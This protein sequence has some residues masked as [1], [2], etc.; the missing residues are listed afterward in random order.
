MGLII[1][2]LLFGLANPSL[3]YA[4]VREN[5]TL[6]TK[7]KSIVISFAKG[8]SKLSVEEN[9]KM[10]AAI[11]NAESNSKIIRVEVAAW[12]DKEHP[13]SGDLPRD[14][15]MLADDRIEQIK[16]AIILN[17]KSIERVKSFNMARNA[18]WLSRKLATSEVKLHD[19]FT[20]R[21]NIN[22]EEI[23]EDFKLI[24]ALG[25]PS[26]AVVILK[27]EEEVKI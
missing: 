26:K 3:T 14:D 27:I 1:L 20:K 8:G 13:Y 24:K 12:S 7:F 11:Q 18:H 17:H 21:K 10:K 4:K 22:N 19:M 25:A 6:I 9:N 15:F 2:S 16:Q 23:R 5:H